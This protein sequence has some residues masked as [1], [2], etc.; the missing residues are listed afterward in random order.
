MGLLQLLL[1]KRC[2]S[3]EDILLDGEK[4][5]CTTC[6]H[7]LPVL[8]PL[9]LQYFIQ[10]FNFPLNDILYFDVLFLYEKH[11]VVQALI[12]KLKYKEYYHIGDMI[13]KWQLANIEKVH[14]TLP[15]DY[16]IPVPIHKKRLQ[17]RGYNQLESYGNVI[18][19]ALQI[20]FRTDILQKT[21]Y[22]RRLATFN[23]TDRAQNIKHSFQI[24][25]TSQLQGKHV[26]ILDDI[27]TTGATIKE[28]ISNFETIKN[29]KI[30]IACMA[31]TK[32]ED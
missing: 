27:I 4:Q 2:Y 14:D 7:S 30:S 5:L 28:V 16:I 22:H 8:T 26:L 17:E 23:L 12:H 10:L 31:I 9:K 32:P 1:P 6:R 21:K 25:N 3:C 15:I 13:G 24:T 18:A 11:N 20:P 19:E 29:C